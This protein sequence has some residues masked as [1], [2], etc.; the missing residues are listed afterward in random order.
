M[1][2]FYC[3]YNDPVYVKLEKIDVLVK[4]ADEKNVDGIL[5]ELKEYSNDMDFDI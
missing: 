5:G 1:K 4:V 2:V 3:K